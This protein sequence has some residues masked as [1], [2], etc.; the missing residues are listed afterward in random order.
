[1]KEKVNAYACS[2]LQ[3]FIQN[4][5][6]QSATFNSSRLIE[7]LF[8]SCFGHA[9]LQRISQLHQIDLMHLT[10]DAI[11]VLFSGLANVTITDLKELYNEIISDFDHV[12]YLNTEQMQQLRVL[13]KDEEEHFLNFNQLNKVHVDALMF[14]L[15]PFSS[16]EDIFLRKSPTLDPKAKICGKNSIGL[17]ELAYINNYLRLCNDLT[18]LERMMFY[19]KRLTDREPPIGLIIPHELGYYEVRSII[20]GNVN[21]ADR[22]GAFFEGG[23]YVTALKAITPKVSGFS[24]MLLFRGTRIN[25]HAQDTMKTVFDNCRKAQGSDGAMQV[26]HRIYDLVNDRTFSEPNEL[27]CVLGMSLGGAHA[28]RIAIAFYDRVQRFELVSPV[29]LDDPSLD[30]YAV[31]NTQLPFTPHLIRVVEIEETVPHLGDGHL[32]RGCTNLLIDL[33]GIECSPHSEQIEDEMRFII[34]K[35]VWPDTY[36]TQA[37]GTVSAFTKLVSSL[38]DTH[39]RNAFEITKPIIY[40]V[41]H[42]DKVLVEQLLTNHQDSRSYTEKFRSAL[43]PF[44]H[45]NK[46][47]YFLLAYAERHRYD[48]LAANCVFGNMT[49]QNSLLQVIRQAIYK[50]SDQCKT[51]NRQIIEDNEIESGLNLLINVEKSQDTDQIKNSI[52]ELLQGK[53]SLAYTS[54][55]NFWN[56]FRAT[57]STFFADS[58]KLSLTHYLLIEFNSSFPQWRLFD[59]AKLEGNTCVTKQVDLVTV[60]ATIYDELGK[61]GRSQEDLSF[62]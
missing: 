14:V 28:A 1:M 3:I 4:L 20:Y 43:I 36:F 44:Q 53:T 15:I 12:R 57:T 26:F 30:Y 41:T 49:L 17:A 25:K 61:C 52:I 16:L 29:G 59:V 33:Y 18:P 31:K 32:G 45:P 2:E 48:G 38:G 40:H 50:Y 60:I 54:S 58:V 56:S 21:E 9:R 55:R 22:V 11:A 39:I 7:E 47:L 13:L 27:F 34:K 46:Y 24:N 5:V 37:Q 10:I 23:A 51:Q 19:A 42:E 62:S 8:I 6:D 35:G